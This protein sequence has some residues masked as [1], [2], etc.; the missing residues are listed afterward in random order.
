MHGAA[1]RVKGAD[2]PFAD[3]ASHLRELFV[4]GRAI[5]AIMAS[6][7]LI[8]ILQPVLDRKKVDPP[9][10]ALSA[11]GA[12]IVPLLG[13]HHGANRLAKLLAK[14]TGGHAAITTVSDV[15]LAVALDDPPPGY[16]LT[17]PHDAKMVTAELF[18]GKAAKLTGAAPWLKN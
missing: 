4:A 17:N 6:G 2:V 14:E 9:V 10:V 7:A 18:E 3:P 15:V 1:H 5:I 16:V 8:R 12:S 13:G 11:D